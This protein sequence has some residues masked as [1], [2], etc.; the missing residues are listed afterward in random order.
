[1]WLPFLVFETGL[2]FSFS[3]PLG[4]SHCTTLWGACQGVS[5]TFFEFE[6]RLG[7]WGVGGVPWNNSIIPQIWDMSS[8]FSKLGL[9]SF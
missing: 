5:Q 3:C 4:H 9:L 2:V 7:N 1:M 6:P 8:V